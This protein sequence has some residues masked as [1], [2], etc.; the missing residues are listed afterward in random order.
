MTEQCDP[1]RCPECMS[2]LCD[3]CVEDFELGMPDGR[4]LVVPEIPVWHCGVCGARWLGPVASD[5]ADEFVRRG[6]E[7]KGTDLRSESSSP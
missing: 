1:G 6:G 4:I 7:W 3:E 2:A 5:A